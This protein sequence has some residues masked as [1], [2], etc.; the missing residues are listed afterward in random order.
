MLY[1]IA[2]EKAVFGRPERCNVEES[3]G[4]WICSC[5]C[6]DVVIVMGVG[7]NV[8]RIREP[9]TGTNLEVLIVHNT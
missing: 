7:D 6:G 5:F 3:I 9:N 4:V 8:F 1:I 2:W